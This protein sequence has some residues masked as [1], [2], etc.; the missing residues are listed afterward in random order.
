[1]KTHAVGAKQVILAEGMDDFFAN[2]DLVV[3]R[4]G[5]PRRNLRFYNAQVGTTRDLVYLDTTVSVPTFSRDGTR[6]ALSLTPSADL[7][8]VQSAD[9]ARSTDLWVLDRATGLRRHVAAHAFGAAWSPD[10]SRIAFGRVEIG[11]NELW[12]V[13]SAG[14]EPVRIGDEKTR[15]FGLDFT[16]DGKA[17]VYSDNA[18]GRITL[19]S[20]AANAKP[21]PLFD[22][23]AGEE[24][25]ALFSPNGKWLLYQSFDAMSGRAVVRAWPSLDHRTVIMPVGNCG[26]RWGDGGKRIYGC[27]PDGNVVWI[28]FNDA[29]GEPIGLPQPVPQ[30]PQSEPDFDVNPR[31]LDMAWITAPPRFGTEPLVL[32]HWRTDAE[33]RLHEQRTR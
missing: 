14:G 28:G 11:S 22:D 16:P 25:D 17:L 27:S 26:A 7:A 20:L 18:T 23:D 4:P 3:L 29:T 33:R 13:P 10:D 31:G 2:G 9:Q 1:V 6:L 12:I 24:G 21:A 30:V 19:Q 32:A 5:V 8:S 15:K